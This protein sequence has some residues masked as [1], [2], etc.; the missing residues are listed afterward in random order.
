[1]SMETEFLK[2]SCEKLE[3]LT[4]RIETCLDMLEPD[5]IWMRGGEN[6]NAIGNLVL[7][8]AGNVRQWILHGIG[9]EEDHRIRDLE[10]STRERVSVDDLKQRL[11]D[12]VNGAIKLLDTLPPENLEGRVT[13]QSYNDITKLRVVYHVVEHFSGHA[14]Q[15]IFWTKWLTGE[16]L[17]FYKHLSNAAHSQ[18]VP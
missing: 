10:F 12:S 14:G 17:G 18:R 11:R 16:D 6:Q 1:M 15:I 13:I 3:Q 2:Y 4:C 9:G 5:Q 8:L 7:H